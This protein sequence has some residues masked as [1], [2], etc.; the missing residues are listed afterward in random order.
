MAFTIFL[1]ENN[2]FIYKSQSYPIFCVN[3][4]IF[5]L[6]KA[7][8]FYIILSE[9]TPF[10]NALQ[11]FKFR[12]V[13]VMAFSNLFKNTANDLDKNVKRV[14]ANP[15]T[16]ETPHLLLVKIQES[17]AE[18]M[19]KYASDPEVTRY[20]TWSCHT[21]L[22]ETQRHIKLLQKKYASGAF[23]DWGLILK[24]SGRM[25]GTCGFTS[26]D[27][28]HLTA[29]IGYVVA[30]DMWGNGYAAEAAK[31]VMQFGREEF[32]LTGF[33]AKMIEGN[34]ASLSVMKKCGMKLEGVFKNS[35]F[36]KGEYKNIVVCSVA[37]E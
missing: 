2:I 11:K 3:I 5:I 17:H 23:N 36:I 20:L 9:E 15:P 18:D 24:G 35:M 4:H 26:F 10:C 25:I 31:R 6:K 30:R 14:F 8:G 1:R 27:Y 12:K 21:S 19:Y 22:K 34:D 13:Y 32:G 37:F 33:C 28:E 7:P 16:L 29:E